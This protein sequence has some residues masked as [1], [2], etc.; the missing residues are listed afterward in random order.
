VKVR[1]TQ[2]AERDIAQA[3]EWYSGRNRTLATR[4]L[5]AVDETTSRIAAQPL[6]HRIAFDDVR[7]A[8]FPR[9]WPYSLYYRVIPDEAIVIAALH[10]RT[11]WASRLRGRSLG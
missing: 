6:A 9:R 8:N 4:F 11:D 7:R 1:F 3:A 10:G 2:D 5:A